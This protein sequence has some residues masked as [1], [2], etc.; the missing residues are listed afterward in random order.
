MLL[1]RILPQGSLQQ[2]LEVS[3]WPAGTYILQAGEQ[4]LRL[5]VE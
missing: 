2:Q 4:S 5:V 1:Q 3:N